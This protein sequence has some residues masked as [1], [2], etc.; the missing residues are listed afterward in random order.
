MVAV[1]LLL[2]Q[3]VQSRGAFHEGVVASQISNL[4][5]GQ[6]Y[7]ALQPTKIL[8]YAMQTTVPSNTTAD[9]C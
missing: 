8:T 6:C 2:L 4:V 7:T 1:V 3:L 9:P 5:G